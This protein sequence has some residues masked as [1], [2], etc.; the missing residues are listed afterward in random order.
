MNLKNIIYINYVVN[1]TKSIVT[2]LCFNIH[3]YKYL[4]NYTYHVS[5]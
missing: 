4:N 5:L 2:L 1:D 3:L